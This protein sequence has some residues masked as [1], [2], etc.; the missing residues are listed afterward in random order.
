MPHILLAKTI[1]RELDVAF[2]CDENIVKLQ[3][4]V[5]NAVL[6]QILQSHAHFRGVESG[7]L[8]TKWTALEVLHEITPTD[9]L[10]DKVEMGIGLEA[11]VELDQEGM[12]FAVNRLKHSLL[13]PYEVPFIVF[14][15]G[16][17]LQDLNGE[18]RAGGLFRLC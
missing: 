11:G 10:A 18:K 4:A 7:L 15:D 8:H 2:L 5:Q 16:L 1:V 6:V 3:V 13:G 14:D 9:V 12:W 17:F